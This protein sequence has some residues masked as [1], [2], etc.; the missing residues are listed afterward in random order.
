MVVLALLATL[1]FAAS[2]PLPPPRSFVARELPAQAVLPQAGASGV[3]RPGTDP[4]PAWERDHKISHM[5]FG[6]QYG[7]AAHP[8]VQK[9]IAVAR[10]FGAVEILDLAAGR[11]VTALAL[12]ADDPQ[13]R[14]LATDIDG[15]GLKSAAHAVPTRVL[16][17]AG[18]RLPDELRGR[19]DFVVAK[20]VYPF[21]TPR[22]TRRL[23]RNAADAL[24][25]GGVMLITAPNTGSQLYRDAS[26]ANRS[27]SHYQKLSLEQRAFVPTARTHFSFTDAKGLARRLRA[28]GLE[29]VSSEDYG[30]AKGWL[31]A[32]ARRKGE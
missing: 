24:K 26:A 30:R 17:A 31:M 8:V 4:G 5:G 18:D 15:E 16:D 10:D 25:P 23:L 2:R 29:L 20:D 9:A 3:E 32:V 19:F 6:K 14:I 21:L 13:R 27:T 1:A 7:D 22:Q 12:K 11:G 28:A